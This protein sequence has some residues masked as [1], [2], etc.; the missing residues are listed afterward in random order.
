MVLVIIGRPQ[1]WS[2]ESTHFHGTNVV[3][4][5]VFSGG[6]RTPLVGAYLPLSILKHLP[7]LEEAL[8]RFQNQ[9]PIVL[10]NLNS[11][12]G[13]AQ[14]TCS[15]QLSELL[16]DFGRVDLLRNFF[17]HLRFRRLKR[18]CTPGSVD[19]CRRIATTYWEHTHDSLKWWV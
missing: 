8:N 1:V 17:Q 13:Q 3:R 6:N 19:C 11:D 2:T 14:N 10:G 4:C 16:I 18:G 5:K 15:Q 9:D 12:I 7:N